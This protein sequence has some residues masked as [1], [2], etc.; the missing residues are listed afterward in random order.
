MVQTVFTRKDVHVAESNAGQIINKIKA[1]PSYAHTLLYPGKQISDFDLQGLAVDIMKSGFPSLDKNMVFKR[2]RG[3]LVIIGARPSKGKSALGFQIATNVARSDKVHVFSL[4]MDHDSIAARQMSVAM[5]RPLDYIQKGG[6]NSTLG[7]E[8]KESLKS[9][10]CHIDDT[11]GLNVHQICERAKMQNKL[12]RTTLIVVDYLQLIDV[13]G[14]NRAVALGKVSYMLKS[15]AKEL[16][17]PVLA[18]CQLNRQSEFREG[19]RPQ[20]SDLK[21]SG[22]IEQDADVVLLIHRQDTD[23]ENAT[24]I[25]AKN[26]NGPTDDIA[27]KFAPAQCRFIDKES[28]ELE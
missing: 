12:G 28:N 17:V 10:N 15:L 2:G 3:E 20:L 8:A 21:E 27:M 13:E 6:A 23:R 16:R 18:M 5:N 25:I 14:E 26:R 22:A 1:D 11:P 4:E 19:G 7:I 9:L 24:I